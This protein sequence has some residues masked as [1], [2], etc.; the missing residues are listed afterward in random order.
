MLSSVIFF[1]PSLVVTLL[2]FFILSVIVCILNVPPRV[3]YLNTRS[4]VGVA[5][6][7]GYGILFSV[8]VIECWVSWQKSARGETVYPP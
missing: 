4:A 1:S 7:G 8:A 2:A 5:V 6:W 3:M